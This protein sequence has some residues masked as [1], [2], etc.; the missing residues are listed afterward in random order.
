MYASSMAVNH[1]PL[2]KIASAKFFRGIINIYL[3]FM[4]FRHID[5]SQAVEILPQVGQE[6]TYST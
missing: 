1:L 3:Q 5:M 6:R 2:F 4:S